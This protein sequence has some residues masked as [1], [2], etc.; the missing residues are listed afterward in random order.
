MLMR[1]RM[2]TGSQRW[3]NDWNDPHASLK[4]ESDSVDYV[5]SSEMYMFSFKKLV[6][7]DAQNDDTDHSHSWRV[8]GKVNSTLPKFELIDYRAGTRL[9]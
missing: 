8:E 6:P 1:P 3:W 9:F 4:Y 2:M 5:E 7:S